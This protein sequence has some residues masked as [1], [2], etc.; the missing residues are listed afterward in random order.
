M[1]YRLVLIYERDSL[2]LLLTKAMNSSNTP[3]TTMRQYLNR[4]TINKVTERTNSKRRDK[5]CIACK[6]IRGVE[7]CTFVM[8]VNV[9][10][11]LGLIFLVRQE[12]PF[13]KLSIKFCIRNSFLCR[14]QVGIG[15][16]IRCVPL[17]GKFQL[18]PIHLIK[19]LHELRLVIPILP[20]ASRNV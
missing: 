7:T 20:I 1:P 13:V 18:F 10:L 11:F 8:D 16:C 5:A 12:K 15:I 4:I 2:K 14:D 17:V 3:Q 9:T 6:T 19:H